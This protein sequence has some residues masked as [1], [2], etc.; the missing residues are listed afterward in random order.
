MY[1]GS[2]LESLLTREQRSG[3][4]HN[5]GEH[6]LD[7]KLSLE[8]LKAFLDLVL[9]NFRNHEGAVPF[10]ESVKERFAKTYPRL[11]SAL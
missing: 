1:Y 5:G 7:L 8:D 9:E 2:F 3:Y 10:V 4:P 11:A 6:T